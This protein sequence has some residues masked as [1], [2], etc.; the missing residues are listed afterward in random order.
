MLLGTMSS[1]KMTVQEQKDRI[2]TVF[3]K[4]KVQ[5]ETFGVSI[6]EK[7]LPT[8]KKEATRMLLHKKP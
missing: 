3:A 2:T 6:E 4:L 1:E 8:L 5:S 7:V